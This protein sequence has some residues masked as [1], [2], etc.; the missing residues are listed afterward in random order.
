MVGGASMSFQI[1]RKV[2]SRGEVRERIL[3]V[4]GEILRIGRSVSSE[5]RLE[6]LSVSLNHA[7]IRLDEQGRYILRDTSKVQ[8]T[9]VNRAP[10]E[11]AVLCHGD[12][13]RIQ[14]YLLSVSQP[15][16]SGPFV[17]AVE[18]TPRTQIEP[19][20]ALMPKFQLSGGRWS[21]GRIASVLTLLVLVGSILALALEKREVFMPGPVS[22]KHSKF[23][24]QC[25]VC[26]ASMKPVWNFVG[27]AACQTC[28]RS[29]ILSPAHF[30][31]EVALSP[32]PLCASCH[33]EHKGQKVLA[34][35]PDTKCVQCHGDLKA[36]DQQ[37]PDIAA[38]HS[39]T[40]DHPEFA[41][42]RSRPDRAVPLRVRLNDKAQLKDDG[43]LKLNHALHLE[44]EKD[45][46][47]TM[48]LKPLTCS[49]CHRIDNEGRNM[50][51]ITFQR[52]CRQCHAADLE[53]AQL[54]PGRSVTHGRQ[55]AAVRQQLVEIFSTVYLQNHPEEA[56]KPEHLRWIPGRRLPG[57]PQTEQERYVVDRQAEAEKILFSSKIRRCLKCHFAESPVS[58]LPPSASENRAMSSQVA[59]REK[60]EARALRLAA[61]PPSLSPNRDEKDV[62]RGNNGTND[63]SDKS[64]KNVSVY[65]IARATREGMDVFLPNM[66]TLDSSYTSTLPSPGLFL[67]ASVNVPVRWLPYS[68]FDHQ[69]HSALPELKAKGKGNWCVACHE[70]APASRKTEDVLLPSIGL[71]RNCHMEPGGAQSSC[72]SCHNF[73]VPKPPD[74]LASVPHQSDPNVASP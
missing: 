68:R 58:D 41:V 16:L 62:G 63:E 2:S 19:S 33:L 35:V 22:V 46:L 73:H 65:P 60:E 25:E 23:A 50:Q 69:A 36:R 67:I 49:E 42:S 61:S 7:E 21:K 53:F 20:L 8:A 71:C 43:R 29:D 66:I 24:H 10:V 48:G 18:E 13:I 6:D 70:S 31:Q 9:Y 55:P 38:V 30:K 74:P 37:V 39:F 45:Y 26:H 64:G 34:D 56:K 5:L 4:S 1:I 51:P 12:V 14:H 15:D 52:D 54:L 3:E 59:T 27:N 72:R 28:H 32:S 11:E 44:L 40:N 47:E 57:Q 17:L